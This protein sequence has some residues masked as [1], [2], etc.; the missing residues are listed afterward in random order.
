MRAPPAASTTSA[1]RPRHAPADDTQ[2]PALGGGAEAGDAAELLARA[3]L[4]RAARRFNEASGLY[5]ELAGRFPD[6][7]ETMV[8]RVLD[9]QL[10]LDNLN[11]PARALA[12]FERYLANEPTGTLAEEA[13][14]GRARALANLDR[15]NDERA[16]WLDLLARHPRSVH[17]SLARARLAALGRP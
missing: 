17:A 2:P 14:V 12:R 6:A 10:L 5:Q 15:R 9:G 4:A 16:A 1:A 11:D 8:A 3:E 13:R 7:R